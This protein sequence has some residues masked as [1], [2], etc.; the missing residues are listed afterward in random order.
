MR[1]EATSAHN[2][3]LGQ[4]R[5]DAPIAGAVGVGQG[6]EDHVTDSGPTPVEHKTALP[7]ALDGLCSWF[8]RGAGKLK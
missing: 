8:R 7:G 6:A 3:T 1:V 2:E 4:V 5:I